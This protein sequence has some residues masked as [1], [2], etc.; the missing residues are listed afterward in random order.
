M[1]YQQLKTA[2][3]PRYDNLN[4]STAIDLSLYRE[5]FEAFINPHYH[6]VSNGNLK[7]EISLGEMMGT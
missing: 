1:I 4:N 5:T 6:D 3:K 7:A 2:T